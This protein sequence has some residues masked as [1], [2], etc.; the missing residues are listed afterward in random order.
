MKRRQ[1]IKTS[2]AVAT[3][4]PALG[5]RPSQASKSHL[6]TFSFDDGFRKSFLKLADIHEEY[7]LKAC[8]NIIASGHMPDFQQVDDWI[9]PELMGDFSDWNGLVARGHEVMPHSWQHLNLARQEPYEAKKLISKCIVYFNENLQGFD[10][11]K[12][13]FNFPFN[14]STPA[15][16]L[17]TIKKVRAVR[18]WG[19]GA[20]NPLPS[21][22]SSRILGCASNGPDL[23]DDWVDE[24]VNSF[25][26][27]EGGWLVLNLH[28]LDNEGWGPLSTD[29]FTSLL[30]KLV[31]IKSLEILPAGM[32]LE[33]YG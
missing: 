23:I 29:Y 16:D 2:A 7:G 3:L 13:V 27:H 5:F 28:G 25:L 1:F 24:K 18:T 10:P 32:A 21:K 15:L 11:S 8:L 33:K 22:T 9:L 26:K 14:A 31:E 30:K 6:I 20:V 19:D 17:F 12:A 4:A